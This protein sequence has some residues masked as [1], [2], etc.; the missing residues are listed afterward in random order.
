MTV[1]RIVT[2]IIGGGQAG[3]TMSHALNQRGLPHIVLERHRI[4][5]RWR[6]ERWESLRFQ[7]PNWA[8]RL[9][10]FSYTGDKPDDYAPRDEVVRFIEA[11]AE[12][13]GAPVRIGV[14]VRAPRHTPDGGAFRLDTSAGTIQARNVVIAT[15][16]YQRPVIP[17]AAAGLGEIGPDHGQ[18]LPRAG[19]I[20]TGRRA[21]GGC[22]R[23]GLSDR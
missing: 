14:D 3:L 5:E 18:P 23:F 16:P 6:S 9:P 10:D 12:R 17:D 2:V 11:Y 1:E 19:P 8:L 21:G 20:A 22:W 4:A 13:I 7:F 15:G